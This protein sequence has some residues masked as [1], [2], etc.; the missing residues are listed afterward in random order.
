[1][2]I[3]ERIVPTLEQIMNKTNSLLSNANQPLL[4]VGLGFIGLA[5][6]GALF[7]QFIDPNQIQVGFTD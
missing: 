1:M 6:V 7:V 2:T 4:I 5:V 3:K